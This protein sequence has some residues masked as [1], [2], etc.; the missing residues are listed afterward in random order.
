ML[1]T[2]LFFVVI[3]VSFYVLL[4]EASPV[5]TFD[6]KTC[7]RKL[8][9]RYQK[10][11]KVPTTVWSSVFQVDLD[12]IYTRLSWVKEE[13][14][15]AWSPKK[16]LNHYT[17][18]FTEKTKN[19]ALPKRILVQ[20]ETGIGKTTFIKRLLVDWSNLADAKIDKEQKDALRKF[21]LVVSINLKK[22]SKCQ[23][24]K[25]VISASQ[26]FPKDE[27]KSV[28]D[29]LSFMRRN[30]EK[31]LVV[32]DGYDEYR[33]GSEA[34]EKYGSRSNSPIYEIFHGNILRDC[35]VLVTTRSSRA[36]EIRGPADIQATVTGF[37]LSDRNEFMRKMLGSLSQDVDLL[38]FLKKMRNFGHEK[39]S[40]HAFIK[41]VILRESFLSAT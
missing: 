19:G 38:L 26:L 27:E 29:L 18:L 16:E 41:R 6:V 36:D 24:L 13:Q 25:E 15:T 40:Q 5:D 31:V 10:T 11:A 32:F 37:N 12:Q 23:T 17:E 21:E 9:E 2:V 34:E 7:Q 4:S 20:G 8:A 39:N 30:Q 14:T 22:V 35:T 28:D 1:F 33:T 3:S